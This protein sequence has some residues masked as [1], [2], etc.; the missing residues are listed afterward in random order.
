[1][2]SFVVGG[3]QVNSWRQ[4]RHGT[5]RAPFTSGFGVIDKR[6]HVQSLRDLTEIEVPF[7]AIPEA[8]TAHRFAIVANAIA[9]EP[10]S[11]IANL[12][13]EFLDTGHTGLAPASIDARRTGPALDLD[14]SLSSCL[15]V[16]T[17]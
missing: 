3:S 13:F 16:L 1:V 11:A 10:A 9:L 4:R 7:V 14:Q 6:D 8:T 5:I 2:V 17:A 15:H 12:V